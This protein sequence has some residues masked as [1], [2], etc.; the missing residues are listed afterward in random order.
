MRSSYNI[1]SLVLYRSYR[2]LHYVASNPDL[3]EILQLLMDREADVNA[4]ND[5]GFSPLFFAAQNSCI[6]NAS[7]LISKGTYINI[8]LFTTHVLENVAELENHINN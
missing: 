4:L 8:M 1:R 3:S 6:Y 5:D 2:P 7:L